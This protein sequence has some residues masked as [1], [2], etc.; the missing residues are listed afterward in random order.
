F[1]LGDA[2]QKGCAARKT[3]LCIDGDLPNHGIWNNPE[4]AGGE[5][6][7]Q[8]QVDGTGQ[9]SRGAALLGSRH[10]Q[11][12]SG[13][14]E[15]LH[16]QTVARAVFQEHPIRELRPSLFAA[17]DPEYGLNAVVKTRQVCVA[18]WP[19]VAES[20]VILAP[21]FVIAQSPGS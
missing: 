20:V 19:V 8:K 13:F 10:V 7:G 9:R 14:D 17:S 18:D 2:I 6:I 5:R 16:A 1:T 11:T 3:R 21:E 12:L 4:I 15:S